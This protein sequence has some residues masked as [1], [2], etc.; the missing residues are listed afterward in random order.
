LPDRLVIR[1]T[2]DSMIVEEHRGHDIATVTYPFTTTV[3]NQLPAGNRAGVMA[4]YVSRWKD[5]K[6]ITTISVEFLAGAGARVVFLETRYVGIDGRLVVETTTPE[7][8]R[9]RTSVYNLL[10]R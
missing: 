6:L 9:K 10:P 2:A 3:S 8:F 5:Q 1:Q 4:E 7:S